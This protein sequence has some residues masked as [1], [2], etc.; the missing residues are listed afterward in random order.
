MYRFAH[1]HD[2][3]RVISY[4]EGRIIQ[5]DYNVKH[6]KQTYVYIPPQ[7]LFLFFGVFFYSLCVCCVLPLNH[8]EFVL[9]H[10]VRWWLLSFFFFPSNT[11]C[12][13]CLLL[14]KSKSCV[15]LPH[16]RA[17]LLCPGIG[18]RQSILVQQTVSILVP[19]LHHFSD[20]NLHMRLNIWWEFALNSSSV[21]T[22]SFFQI[23]L[24]A[25][26]RLWRKIRLRFSG[27]P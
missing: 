6:E 18:F 11:Q 23:N 22:S 1:Y 10:S 4:S 12:S 21:T 7:V 9:K 17:S 13:Q 15:A 26:C 5:M 27:L 19:T 25:L 3:K 8:L 24:E 2:H 14:I 16:Q 20:W